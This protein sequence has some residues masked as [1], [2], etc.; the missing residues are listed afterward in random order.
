MSRSVPS[1]RTIQS[2]TGPRG[3]AASSLRASATTDRTACEWIAALRRWRF[4]PVEGLRPGTGRL[5]LGEPGGL[6]S[7]VSL[8]PVPCYED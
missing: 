3:A 4:V 6:Q 7:Q 8:D 2:T 1:H 5:S